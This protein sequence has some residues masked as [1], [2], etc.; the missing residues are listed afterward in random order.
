MFLASANK[1]LLQH[2][3]PLPNQQRQDLLLA[4]QVLPRLVF[5]TDLPL[6][7]HSVVDSLPPSSRSLLCPI[8]RRPLYQAIQLI[9]E[10]HSQPRAASLNSPL[11]PRP[12][13]HSP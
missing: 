5:P 13:S 10:R 2:P 11:R 1:P 3:N 7:A 12:F 8:I 6:E 4:S 9:M